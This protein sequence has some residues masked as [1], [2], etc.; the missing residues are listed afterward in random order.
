MV[1]DHPTF[2]RRVTRIRNRARILANL[3]NAS[4]VRWAI[5][6]SIAF[7]I[8]ATDVGITQKPD[9]ASTNGLMGNSRTIGVSSTG[10]VVHPANGG[11]FSKAAGMSLLTFGIRLASQLL[12]EDFRVTVEAGDAGTHGAMIDNVA[13]GVEAAAARVFTNGVDTGSG[14]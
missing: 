6:I 5:R 9:G 12:A 11:T 14:F 10:K 1:I 7:N 4:L 8:I 13:L 3:V 2:G